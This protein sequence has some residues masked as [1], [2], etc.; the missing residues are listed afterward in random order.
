MVSE[1]T[2]MKHSFHLD[3]AA[4]LTYITE[5]VLLA[6]SVEIIYISETYL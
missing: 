5:K 3:H 6:V 1:L 4:A 2:T